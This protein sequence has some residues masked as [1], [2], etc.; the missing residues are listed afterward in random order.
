MDNWKDEIAPYEGADNRRSVWQLI[1]TVLPFFALWILAY[2]SLSVSYWLSLVFIIPAAGFLVRI[3]ILFHDCTHQSFFT[4]RRA[5]EITG[6]VTGLLTSFPYHQWKHEHAV[7]HATNS[8]LGKRGTG[9]IW[10]LTVDEYMA[11]PRLKRLV[12]RFYRHPLTMF[13]IGPI[14]IILGAYRYNRK[15][16]SRTERWNTYMT[17][18]L[19]PLIGGL[20]CWW[21]GWKSVLLIEGPILY[22]SAMA[23]IWL[24]YVQHQFE[25]TY[26]EQPEEWDFVRA[27]MEGSSFYQLPKVLQW[28]VGNIG[29]HHI[30]HLS[31]RVPNYKLQQLYENHPS[32]QRVTAVRFFASFQALRF[33]LWDEQAKRFVAFREVAR[34][35]MTNPPSA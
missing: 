11:L 13:G 2:L 33:R 16:S 14:Y 21:L 25:N 5:N 18:A 22:L 4:N 6:I 24:F 9:D 20:L 10:T 26:F 35:R 23:G 28:M 30:H 17:N 7:H 27:A 31:S 32:L 3:F 34:R 29:Y 19:L 1:N 15:G 12:Y 8:N